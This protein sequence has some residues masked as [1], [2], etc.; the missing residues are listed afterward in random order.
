MTRTFSI[1]TVLRMVPNNLLKQFLEDLGH[2]GFD[3]KWDE[4]K[5]RDDIVQP[6]LAYMDELPKPQYDQLE[7]GLHNVSDLA[8]DGGF[9]ALLEAGEACNIPN[10]GTLV[11]DNLGVWGRTMWLWLNHR[12]IFEKAQIIHQIEHMAWWR[13]RNDL[14]Q[15]APD[16][17]TKAINK[18][19]RDIS[20][21]LKTQGRGKDCTVERMSRGD[22]HY[23]FAYPDDFV[24]NVL[25]HDSEGRLS[26][27][28]F[29]QTLLIVF[30]YNR[31]EGSLEMYAKG[32]HKPIKEKLEQIFANAILHW[33]LGDFDPEA[34]Y[35]LD[36][37]K[38]PFVDLKTDPSDRISVRIRKIR[39]AS[40]NSGRRIL[41]EVDADDPDD[42]IHTAIEECIN[43]ENAPLSE[44]HATQVTF[45]FEFLPKDGRK[46][47]KQSFDVSYP[48]SC[49]LRNARPERVELIQKYLKRWKIDLA[50]PV[51]SAAVPMGS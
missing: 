13:K 5:K 47:G 12:E 49:S 44:W 34:A 29:R 40:T 20:T 23:F 8:S 33:K 45:R 21:L 3:P 27:E 42:D 15:N 2:G 10:L 24:E 51:E 7:S 14:P 1:P 41:F 43:L 35:E 16:V 32:L 11:P 50:A 38:D 31:A 48:R 9:N 18:L 26:P 39:L 30:A 25:V 6:F 37:L 46:P 36:Q 17:S 28:T 22:M 4:L 19:A